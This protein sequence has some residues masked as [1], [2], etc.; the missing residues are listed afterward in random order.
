M[1]DLRTKAIRL[2]STLPR[3]PERKALLDVLASVRTADAMWH[4]VDGIF[5]WET[6]RGN[7]N[8]QYQRDGKLGLLEYWSKDGDDDDGVLAEDVPFEQAKALALDHSRKERVEEQKQERE[9][10]T[11]DQA[12]RNAI[13]AYRSDSSPYANDFDYARLHYE[14]W[15]TQADQMGILNDPLRRKLNRHNKQIGGL[16]SKRP[17]EA[18]DQE[19]MARGLEM[20]LAA[21]S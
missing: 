16:G 15:L 10:L 9:V 7:Y 19:L 14:R 18:S 12:L 1:S 6:P 20:L 17:G 21:T 11:F 8:F 3:G 4:E 13:R 2:A 5:A